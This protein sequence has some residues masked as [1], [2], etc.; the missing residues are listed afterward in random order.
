MSIRSG[1]FLSHTFVLLLFIIT[2]SF[3]SCFSL[4]SLNF[5]ISY[6]FPFFFNA[7]KPL[8]LSFS[9][10]I[11]RVSMIFYYQRYPSIKVGTILMFF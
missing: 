4:S 2:F 3:I 8:S 10:D 1:F 7:S 9:L 5:M 11:F 6:L